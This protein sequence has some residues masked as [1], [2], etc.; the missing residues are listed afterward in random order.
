[1][2]R[3]I[4]GRGGGRGVRQNRVRGARKQAGVNPRD[5]LKTLSLQA[6]KELEGVREKTRKNKKVA[7]KKKGNQ[8]EIGRGGE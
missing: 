7:L 1:V 5:G 2:V 4:A 6:G 3:R 8:A